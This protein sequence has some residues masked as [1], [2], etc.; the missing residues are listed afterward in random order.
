MIILCY[1]IHKCVTLLIF[2]V[3]SVVFLTQIY[4]RRVHTIEVHMDMVVVMEDMEDMGT[5]DMAM[6]GMGMGAMDI[7]IHI[8]R[9]R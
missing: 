9:Y 2:M 1:C 6:E 7:D 3:D 4:T 5:E 8:R